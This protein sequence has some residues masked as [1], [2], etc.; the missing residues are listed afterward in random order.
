[1]GA[2]GIRVV[3]VIWQKYDVETTRDLDRGIVF[4]GAAR[5]HIGDPVVRR[6]GESELVRWQFSGESLPVFLG[7]G[8]ENANSGS[9]HRSI[10]PSLSS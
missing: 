4:P 7:F 2:S 1:M 9:R 10:L 6:S 3:G 5:V 8:P